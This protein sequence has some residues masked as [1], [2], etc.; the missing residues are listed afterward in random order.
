MRCNVR[1]DMAKV[2][3]ER[4]RYD[5]RNRRPRKGYGRLFRRCPLEDQPTRE[6]I[7]RRGGGTKSFNEHLGPL[8]RYLLGQVG[9]PWDKVFSEI[10]RHLSRNSAV[11]DHVRDHVQD[12]VA[13]E[14]TIVDGVLHGSVR[15]WKN[16]PLYHRS[17]PLYV[18]PRTGILRKVPPGP[19]PYRRTLRRP[20]AGHHFVRLSRTIQF[21]WIDGAWHEIE[22]RPFPNLPMG[23]AHTGIQVLDVFASATRQMPLRQDQA[24][25][26][27]DGY[28]PVRKR[29]L[30]IREARQRPLP[31][32]CGTPQRV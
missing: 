27:F 24:V 22:V 19:S 16:Q 1:S 30:S 31:I 26:W 17:T 2:I 15:Y 25:L 32:L 10:C 12:Y 18:C 29:R 13:T 7:G 9:R 14:V 20:P 11:Q 28:Y 6:G 5:S 8:R 21:H 23:M 4:P 3:V